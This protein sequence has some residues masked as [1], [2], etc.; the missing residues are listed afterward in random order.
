MG[1]PQQCEDC[2]VRHPSPRPQDVAHLHR[3]QHRHPGA[4]QASQ[5][6]VHGHVPTKGFLA[7]VHWR[8]HGRDG[9]HRGREQHERLGLRVPTVPGRHRRGGGRVRGGG[10]RGGGINTHSIHPAPHFCHHPKGGKI[11]SWTKLKAPCLISSDNI[12]SAL[13]GF[14][15]QCVIVVMCFHG[16]YCNIVRVRFHVVDFNSLLS[17]F[18]VFLL[19][20]CDGEVM[21]IY[22]VTKHPFVQLCTTFAIIDTCHNYTN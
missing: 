7:L 9:V 6:T 4:L 11:D 18:C 20:F 3:K 14:N 5:R 1:D 13:F 15:D 16:V 19:C 8:G 12:L 17:V 21:M 22:F 10:G 2:R